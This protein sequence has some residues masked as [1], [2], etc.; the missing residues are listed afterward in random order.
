[1]HKMMLMMAAV[2]TAAL[3]ALPVAP[4]SA[5]GMQQEGQ[6]GARVNAPGAGTAQGPVVRSARPGA[7]MAHPTR[8]QHVKRSRRSTVGSR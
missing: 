4:S 6:G 8:T 1:M 5:Q 7:R 3:L 2:V